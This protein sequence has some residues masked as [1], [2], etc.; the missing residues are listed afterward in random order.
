MLICIVEGEMRYENKIYILF[1]YLSN[2]KKE[3]Y[4]TKYSTTPEV[5][6]K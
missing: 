5:I 6:I 1:R 3:P 4:K 2:K